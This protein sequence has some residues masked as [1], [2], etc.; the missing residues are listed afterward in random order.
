MHDMHLH[1]LPLQT[2]HL[3]SLRAA[4]FSERFSAALRDF[5]PIVAM[6]MPH[7]CTIRDL[8]L[9]EQNEVVTALQ[10][11]EHQNCTSTPTHDN[12]CRYSE[13]KIAK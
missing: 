7:S 8:Y 12:L 5:H 1:L 2:G 4:R 10:L 9:T 3:L 6:K 13:L 11:S